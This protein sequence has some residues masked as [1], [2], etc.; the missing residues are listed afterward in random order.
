MEE[1]AHAKRE[2]VARVRD[3]IANARAIPEGQFVAA[4]TQAF[5]DLGRPLG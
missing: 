2:Q 1:A 4:V 3:D 5:A